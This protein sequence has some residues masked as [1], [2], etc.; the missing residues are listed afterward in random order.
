MGKASGTK[1]F[2]RRGKE[3][4]TEISMWLRDEKDKDP[5]LR[6]E[7]S[8]KKRKKVREMLRRH[9]KVMSGIPGKT[10]L[11]QHNVDVGGVNPI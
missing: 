9:V 7:L 10:E 8:V 1:P 2:G 11:V 3:V 6:K 4:Q 5:S